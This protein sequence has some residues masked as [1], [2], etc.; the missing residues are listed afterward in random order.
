VGQMKRY[1][2]KAAPKSLFLAFL[3]IPHGGLLWG[4]TDGTARFQGTLNDYNGT[5][6]NHYTVGWVTTAGGTFIKSL[7]KQGPSN[8]SSSE[9]TAH[10]G[11]WNTA[12]AGST[13]IDG[14]TSATAT[15]YSGTNSPVI[16]TWNGRDAN[17]NLVPDGVYKFWLQD[18]ENSGQGPHTT[19][20]LI[21]VKGTAAFTTNYPNLA[22]HF[23]SLSTVWT[24]AAPPAP[25]HIASVRLEGANLL[26]TATG[27]VNRAFYVL[28]ATNAAQAPGTWI[29]VATNT[30]DAQGRFSLAIPVGGN[31]R[32]FY[33]LQS[34]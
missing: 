13:S 23:T 8:W 17:N 3:L 25:P 10:C 21:W 28:S 33:R 9:W 30:F 34:Y 7:R 6:L 24:P 2:M 11:V 32:M 4:Q 29:R 27:S 26:M 20:G 31:P 18:A 16:W 22:P 14:Y 1:D 5:S 12:R 15:S 19:N